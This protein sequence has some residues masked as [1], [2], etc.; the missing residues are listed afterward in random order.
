MPALSQQAIVTAFFDD[1]ALLH[2]DNTVCGF[3]SG[4]AVCDQN[5]GCILQDQVQSL[6]NLPF[7]E[8]I[9]AG[10]GFIENKDG[11]VLNQHAHQCHELTL[12]HR[13]PIAA[14]AP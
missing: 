14:L 9:N 10:G 2:N 1:R 12:S 4:K 3:D 5:T 7:S 8:W 13:K 11:G 6:L